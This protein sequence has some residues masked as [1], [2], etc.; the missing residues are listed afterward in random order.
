VLQYA[1]V[2]LR[3]FQITQLSE[4]RKNQGQWQKDNS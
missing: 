2:N 3:D 4:Q 1:S